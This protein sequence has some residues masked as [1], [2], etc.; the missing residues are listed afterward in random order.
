[1]YKDVAIIIVNY[2]SK[3]LLKNCLKSIFSDLENTTLNYSVVVIDND[4]Q[5]DS[6]Q[7]LI[8]E[9]PRTERI[10][11]KNNLGYAR[12]VNLGLKKFPAK[13]YFVLNPDTLFLEK[14]VIERLFNFMEAH[15]RVGLVG[16]KL[17]N[18]DRSIQYSACRFPNFWVPIYRRT[19]LGKL[20]RASQKIDHFLMH[21]WDHRDTREVDWVLGTG[22]FVRHQAMEEV[23]G[24]DERFFMYFEDVDWCRR[25]KEK[26]WPVYY[27]ADVE[28]IHY[29]GRPSAEMTGI[30]SILFSR[31]TRI[32]IASW[33]KYF[34]KYWLHK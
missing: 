34:L 11:L 25:F 2:K 14:K 1:M 10:F 29:H 31:G 33:L 5:D 21:E 16:P 22:M 24:M 30:K 19:K 20:K 28:V 7:M 32:H 18:P 8:Q 26:N 3:G 9:F 4:S 23:G 12:A 17:I 15:P 6:E 13:Y 27:L